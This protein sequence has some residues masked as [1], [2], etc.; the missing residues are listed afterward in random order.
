[1]FVQLSKRYI[2]KKIA[3]GMIRV[4]KS[5]GSILLIDWRYGKLNNPR[6]LALNKKRVKEIFE[7]NKSTHLISIV[8][9]MLIPPIGRFVSRNFSFLYFTVAKTCPFLV[10]QVGYILKKV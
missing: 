3:E 10:G 6:F 2:S 7:V 4:T 8:P 9:G 5:K 1:M